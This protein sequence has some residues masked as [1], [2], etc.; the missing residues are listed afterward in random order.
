MLFYGF[1]EW[2]DGTTK[3][4]MQAVRQ[5]GM[6]RLSYYDNQDNTKVGSKGS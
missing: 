3:V 1:G 5:Q 4:E 2:M 6:Y